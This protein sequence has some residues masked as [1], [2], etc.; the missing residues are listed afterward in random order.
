MVEFTGERVIPG[1]VDDNLWSEHFAR[2]A[3]ARRF[4]D[5]KRVLD[6]GCGVGYG[7]AELAFSAAYVVAVDLAPDAL[8]FARENYGLPNLRLV[9]GSCTSLPFPKA[10][11]DLITAFEVIEHLND[12]RKFIGECARVLAPEGMLVVSSPNKLYYTESRGKTGPNPFHE[13]EFEPEEFAA[14]LKKAF[15]NVSIIAQNHT[16][17]ITFHPLRRCFSTETRPGT[18]MDSMDAANT[19]HFLIGLCSFRDP[20]PQPAFV[21]VPKAANLL[22]ERERHI[23]LLQDELDGTKAWLHETQDERAA[24]VDLFRNQKRELEEANRWAAQLDGELKSASQRVDRLQ[25]EAAGLAAGYQAKIDELEAENQAKTEWALG[26]EVRLGAELQEKCRELT[27]CLAL[28]QVAEQ[29][30]EERTLWAQRLDSELNLIRA[31]RWIKLG[32]KVGL[33]PG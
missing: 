30:V 6:A 19:A 26:T 3:F 8:Q 14:E 27:E 22:R 33:G 11:F 1:Q 13:H 21:Y 32:R 12:Y 24:L 17:C 10:S 7:S 29:T 28:L 2:Y 16:E 23:R 20:G 15:P 18:R 9:A 5:G 4:V 31:S 25:L